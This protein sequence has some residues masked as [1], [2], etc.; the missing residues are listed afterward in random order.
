[1]SDQDA[2]GW[3]RLLPRVGGAVARSHRRLLAEHGLTTTSAALLDV[4]DR[5]AGLCHRELAGRLALAPA[6]L[7]PVVDALAAA[8]DVDRA[9]DPRDR[10]V[11]RL[12]ITPAG[13]ARLRTATAAVSAAL[14]TTLPTPP[15]AHAPLIR[16]YLLT[17]L[18][19]LDDPGP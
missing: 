6:T 13:R 2:A 11:V 19:A 4:L 8:G 9:R 7:T 5:H 15:P 16:A 1:V 14:R 17:V 10:R 12:S 3:E 18:T